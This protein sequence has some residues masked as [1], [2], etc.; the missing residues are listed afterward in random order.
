[1]WTKKT[2]KTADLNFRCAHMSEGTFFPLCDSFVF[3][4][5]VLC[6]QIFTIKLNYQPNNGLTYAIA[7]FF[8]FFFFFFFLLFYL[9]RK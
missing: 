5:S 6:S 9:I 3:P 2:D 1:M 4:V 8:F 7:I